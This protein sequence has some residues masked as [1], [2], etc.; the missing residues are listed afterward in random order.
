M[1]ET[2]EERTKLLRAGFTDKAVEKLY[3]EKNNLKI[4]NI[5]VIFELVE[6][7]MPQDKRSVSSEAATG[8]A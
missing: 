8:C 5:P 6:F 4:V 7:D 3:I 1:I 2:P